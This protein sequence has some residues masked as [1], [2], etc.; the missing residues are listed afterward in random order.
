MVTI[1][2]IISG[3]M[4]GGFILNRHKVS[5]FQTYHNM[6]IA[7]ANIYIKRVNTRN[8]NKNLLIFLTMLFGV[9]FSFTSIIA[10]FLFFSMSSKMP[11][12]YK[13]GMIL[14]ASASFLCL[15]IIISLLRYIVIM[16]H[17]NIPPNT[18]DDLSGILL[19]KVAVLHIVV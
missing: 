12:D 1:M 19:E 17:W 9:G 11:L 5:R 4:V 18:E 8:K 3:L 7:E 2:T 14:T 15:F 10:G 13:F 16:A 6:S